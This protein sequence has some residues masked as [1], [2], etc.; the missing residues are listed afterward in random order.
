VILAVLR[1][2][3]DLSRIRPYVQRLR[4]LGF[5]TNDSIA[6]SCELFPVFERW[7]ENGPAQARGELARAA[8]HLEGRKHEERDVL[9][10]RMREWYLTLGML[11]SAEQ[12]EK[13]LE[14]R[15]TLLPRFDY[16]WIAYAR[17][18]MPEFRRRAQALVIE[19]PTGMGAIV[20][21]RAGYVD[22]AE[23]WAATMEKEKRAPLMLV[24]VRG[25]CALARGRRPE[26][27]R[28][29]EEALKQ[30][31]TG[32]YAQ[33]YLCAEDLAEARLQQEGLAGAIETL[34]EASRTRAQIFYRNGMFWLRVQFRLAQLYRQA[35]LESAAGRMEEELRRLLACADPDLRILQQLRQIPAK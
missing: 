11:A 17:G 8:Q 32:I 23:E 18:D 16:P 2:G 5:P 24:V 7:M 10:Y 22:E 35:G 9:L 21:A 13:S 31:R 34:E 30:M 4:Q 1:Q 26:G 15:N 20:L 12:I 25:E 27:I 33:Y 28:L 29:L 19:K 6:A 3:V 14:L